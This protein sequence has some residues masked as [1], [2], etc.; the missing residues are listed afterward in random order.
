[1]WHFFFGHR[2]WRYSDLAVAN[3]NCGKQLRGKSAFK[4]LYSDDWEKWWRLYLSGL[5]VDDG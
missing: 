1:M 2:W 4:V 5:G 3:C